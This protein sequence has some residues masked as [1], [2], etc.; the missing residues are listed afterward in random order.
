MHCSSGIRLEVHLA[1][2]PHVP[3]TRKQPL[4]PQAQLLA[5][6]VA[7]LIEEYRGYYPGMTNRDVR[8]ALR[9]LGSDGPDRGGSPPPRLAL[10]LAGGAAAFAGVMV[11]GFA[12]GAAS[13]PMIMWGVAGLVIALGLAAVFRNR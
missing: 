2:E 1:F 4:S 5:D 12:N 9:T 13:R 10:A 6:K 7:A 11:Y 3:P 8:D